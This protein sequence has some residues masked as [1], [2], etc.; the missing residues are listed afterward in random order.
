MVG[1]PLGSEFPPRAASVGET[2]LE[3]EDLRGGKIRGVSFRLHRGEVLGLAGLAGAGRT[4]LARLLFGADRAEGGTIRLGGRRQRI[5]TPRD[6]IDAGI[7]LLTEDRK[8]EGLVL[9]LSARENFALPNLRRWSRFGWI[10][11][12]RERASFLRYV[13]SLKIRVSSD[14][15]KAA[16]LSGGNQQKLLVA[17]WIEHDARVL[18]FDEP[19]R[20]IDVGAK[21]EMLAL[22]RDLAARGKGI[23]FTSS[24]LPELIGASDRILVLHDGRIAGEIVDVAAATQEQ[25]LRMA[26]L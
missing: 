4:E 3:V 26:V 11:R 7:A 5:R 2:L 8:A 22:I 9:G 25:V 17:R 12:S 14:E 21:T 16:T 1:R 24:E 13:E 20:G 10:D 6:A 19:T 15:Q 23:L 18:L